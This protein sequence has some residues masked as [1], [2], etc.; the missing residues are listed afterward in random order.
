MSLRGNVGLQLRT[1]VARQ[2]SITPGVGQ[3]GVTMAN[4]LDYT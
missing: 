4:G 1:D 2:T 3:S